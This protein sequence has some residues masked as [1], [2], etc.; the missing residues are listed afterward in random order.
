MLQ[1]VE[2][3]LASERRAIR[4]PGHELSAEHGQNR[5]VPQLVM[6]VEVKFSTGTLTLS[7]NTSVVAWFIIVRIAGSAS[8]ATS[9]RADA[10][11]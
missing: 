4:A 1:P 8:S 2:R 7:K 10:R 9:A 3:A 11:R 5:I 6:V